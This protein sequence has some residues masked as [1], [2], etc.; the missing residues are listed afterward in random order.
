MSMINE[1]IKLDTAVHVFM[2][3]VYILCTFYSF[4]FKM[5]EF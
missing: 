3:L 5:E 4:F 2:F 1:A